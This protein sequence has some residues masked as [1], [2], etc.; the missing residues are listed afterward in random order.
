[1]GPRGPYFQVL[2]PRV[3]VPRVCPRACGGSFWSTRPSNSVH[4]SSPRVPGRRAGA[5]R[6]VSD[7][8]FIPARAG[9]RCLWSLPSS[10]RTWFIP[11]RA[12]Q[13]FG[14]G[15]CFTLPSVHPRACGGLSSIPKSSHPKPASSPRARGIPRS[16][17]A[18]GPGD[19]IHPRAHR[20]RATRL[21]RVCLPRFLR[22]RAVDP[23]GCL[24]PCGRGRPDRTVQKLSRS[25]S[26]RVPQGAP[27]SLNVRVRVVALCCSSVALPDPAVPAVPERPPRSGAVAASP[28]ILLFSCRP[29]QVAARSDWFAV[30]LIRIL[31]SHRRPFRRSAF[32]CREEV[33]ERPGSRCL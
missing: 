20:A 33:F 7:A 13:S 29:S 30:P 1:M 21:V 27:V 16:G 12:G 4:G 25:T 9:Q 6:P 10:L 31:D 22:S 17:L 3:R 32:G 19:R 28:A 5:V 15:R 14:T 11:A 23:P 26:R 24:R 8:G 18:E 2:S